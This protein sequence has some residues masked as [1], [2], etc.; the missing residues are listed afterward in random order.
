V[1]VIKI[2]RYF[3]NPVQPVKSMTLLTSLHL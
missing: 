1:S 2:L 3:F